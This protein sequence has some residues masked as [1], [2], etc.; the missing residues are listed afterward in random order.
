[1]LLVDVDELLVCI[2]WVGLG[3]IKWA[4]E[5]FVAGGGCWADIQ[6]K[7]SIYVAVDG[8]SVCLHVGC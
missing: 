1:L 5:H 6:I 4:T 3:D 7:R 8:L 2:F